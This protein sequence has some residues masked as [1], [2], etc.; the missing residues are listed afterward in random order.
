L[1]R[2][3]IEETPS[4]A[5]VPVQAPVQSDGRE[6]SVL[7]QLYDDSGTP[8]GEEAVTSII[9]LRTLALGPPGDHADSREELPVLELPVSELPVS[10][11]P[12]VERTVPS[13]VQA[14]V[15]PRPEPVAEEAPSV[16]EAAVTADADAESTVEAAVEPPYGQA[17]EDQTMIL[18]QLTEAMR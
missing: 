8:A 14:V 6:P 18:P 16:E 7:D 5:A 3:V 15:E 13:P 12:T 10:E 1:P 9:D 4:A 17:P 11:R 2:L